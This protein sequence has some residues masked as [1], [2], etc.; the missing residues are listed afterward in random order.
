[1][2]I[3]LVRHVGGRKEVEMSEKKKRDRDD[4]VRVHFEYPKLLGKEVDRQRKRYG[5]KKRTEFLVAIL[6]FAMVLMDNSIGK[7]GKVGR[8]PITR[9]LKLKDNKEV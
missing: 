8:D 9:Q 6:Q 2:A 3:G 1:M 4:L 7:G 5:Y